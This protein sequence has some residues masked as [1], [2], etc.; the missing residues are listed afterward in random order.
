MQQEVV[1]KSSSTKAIESIASAICA[2]IGA[3]HVDKV[4]G[5][6]QQ[7]NSNYSQYS[8]KM[9]NDETIKVT[10]FEGAQDGEQY[11][12]EA[13]SKGTPFKFYGRSAQL[14]FN[15]LV[16]RLELRQRELN[17][18]AENF[19]A[20]LKI[21]A[22]NIRSSV[23][24]TPSESGCS[25]L[26]T[27]EEPKVKLFCGQNRPNQIFLRGKI[28]DFEIEILRTFEA[29]VA[30]INVISHQVTLRQQI[31]PFFV[32]T[33]ASGDQV[34][35]ALIKLL[36]GAE[37]SSEK[38]CMPQS[39]DASIDS[40]TVAGFLS[41][42]AMLDWMC[43]YGNWCYT[44]NLL[45]TDGGRTW[46]CLQNSHKLSAQHKNAI[47]EKMSQQP[48]DSLL[49]QLEELREERMR[50]AANL[51]Y[52]RDPSATNFITLGL[53]VESLSSDESRGINC[54]DRGYIWE[55]G[56][57]FILVRFL[58]AGIKPVTPNEIKLCS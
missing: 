39:I 10:Y 40:N 42:S 43:R 13:T 22:E 53:P 4:N 15:A 57:D 51:G 54:G 25:E 41:P 55:R 7:G 44:G 49:A 2:K 34:E 48:S 26:L 45:S 52:A 23:N 17:E 1:E 24:W 33:E 20:D 5:N 27:S 28:S 11:C 36:N 56:S 21:H 37:P 30:D 47:I 19:L 32:K 12:L 50:I 16:A 18:R 46:G 29:R 31:G 8:F 38:I 35:V 9:N 14:V 3:L 58:A 6:Y